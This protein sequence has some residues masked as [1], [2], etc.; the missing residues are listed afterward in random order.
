GARDGSVR[1]QRPA[2]ARRGS[3]TTAGDQQDGVRGGRHRRY[4]A[5]AETA[6]RIR[7]P[8]SGESRPANVEVVP[9]RIFGALVE[10]VPNP[11]ERCVLPGDAEPFAGS[12]ERLWRLAM[13]SG[14]VTAP[15]LEQL[16]IHSEDLIQT[17][18][19]LTRKAVDERWGWK[20]RHDGT[21]E[22]CWYRLR[23]DRADGA[24]EAARRS[25]VVSRIA[26]SIPVPG[27]TPSG[28]WQR[29]GVIVG[30]LV[31][32]SL[33]WLVLRW[34]A[35][36][37][38]GLDENHGGKRA[39]PAAAQHARGLLLIGSG[40]PLASEHVHADVFDLG[41]AQSAG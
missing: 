33:L 9:S 10:A 36:R 8:A 24:T 2:Q 29:I 3:G 4:V 17:R 1:P 19:L 14:H 13:A 16:P 7:A 26:S 35:A 28:P 6:R 12:V 18:E 38:V 32:A 21:G 34:L 25:H 11:N 39:L 5:R 41:D 30:F 22:L 20:R 40:C 27:L 37:I 23:R 15:I 31:F